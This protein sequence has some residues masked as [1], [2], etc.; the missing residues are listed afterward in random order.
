MNRA[1]EGIP[2]LPCKLFETG[3]NEE[4]FTLSCTGIGKTHR[5]ELTADFAAAYRCC[6]MDCEF[7]ADLTL[8]S[9]YAFYLSL[10]NALDGLPG[11]DPN[12]VLQSCGSNHAQ[13]SFSPD[14]AGHWIVRGRFKNKD[15][16]YRSGILFDMKIDTMF[17]TEIYVSLERFFKALK[18]Q[19]GSN[20]Y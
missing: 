14:H 4:C 17:V 3:M 18:Q 10:D 13:L 1:S 15:H 9:L 11:T 8:G 6:G 19:Y 7:A 2:M 16:N 5:G 20:F 12:A